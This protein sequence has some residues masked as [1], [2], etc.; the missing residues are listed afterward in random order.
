MWPFDLFR[1]KRALKPEP[2]SSEHMPVGLGAMDHSFGDGREEMINYARLLGQYK[3]LDHT[4]VAA[5]IKREREAEKTKR[6]RLKKRRN[7]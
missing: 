3:G 5:A 2:D 6:R 4:L 1:I 7:D